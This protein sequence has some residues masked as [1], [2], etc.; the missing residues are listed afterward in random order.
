CLLGYNK[1]WL[2]VQV[3]VE[4]PG[5]IDEYRNLDGAN[6]RSSGQGDFNSQSHL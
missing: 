1:S 3:D 5:R 6:E 2:D 4:L